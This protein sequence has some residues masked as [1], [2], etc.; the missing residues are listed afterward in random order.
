M[1]CT[2]HTNKHCKFHCFS[3]TY[4]KTSEYTTTSIKKASPRCN[5]ELIA[6]QIKRSNC[7][8]QLSGS[9]QHGGVLTLALQ[10]KSAN[11]LIYTLI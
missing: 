4:M 9:E 11:T 5:C 3:E 8:R 2:A 6:V 7:M 10:L 1:D